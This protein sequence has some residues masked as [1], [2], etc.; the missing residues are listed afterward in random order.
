MLIVWGAAGVYADAPV[1]SFTLTDPVFGWTYQ[2]SNL[3]GQRTTATGGLPSVFSVNGLNQLQQDWWWYRSGTGTFADT[4]EYALSNE[5]S[6][7][8]LAAN[9]VQLTYLEPAEN[10]GLPGALQFQLEYTLTATSTAAAQVEIDWTVSNLTNNNLAVNMFGYIDPDL[11]NTAD[12]DSALKLQFDNVSGQVRIFDG[13][14]PAT[15]DLIAGTAE[16]SPNLLAW[17]VATFDTTRAKL[18]DGDLDNLS[19]TVSNLLGP[20]DVTTA[21]QWQNTVQA[22]GSCSG[23][24]IKSPSNCIPTPVVPELGSLVLA[25]PGLAALTALRRRKN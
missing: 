25:L 22:G 24:L 8:Q 15:M 1:N 7:T 2:E 10:G 12:N 16:R 18:S 6:F 21:F 5:T 23:T 11:M 14:T 20:G 4:R 13:G 9:K 17:E 3:I 19:N